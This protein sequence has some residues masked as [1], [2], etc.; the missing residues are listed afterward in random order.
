LHD[1]RNQKDHTCAS[2]WHD[3]CQLQLTNWY[4]TVFLY[5]QLPPGPQHTTGSTQQVAVGRH[6]RRVPG[7]T[8]S[9][10]SGEHGEDPPFDRLRTEGKLDVGGKGVGYPQAEVIHRLKFNFVVQFQTF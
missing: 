9:P 2:I 3:S 5:H 10:S 1:G 4:R 8:H 6:N 7:A